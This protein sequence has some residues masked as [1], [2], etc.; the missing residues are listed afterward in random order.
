MAKFIVP[1]ITSYY[2]YLEVEADSKEEAIEKAQDG[3]GQW[4][5]HWQEFRD[6]LDIREEFVKEVVE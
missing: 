6:T 4:I 5:E 2:E 3:D 1:F